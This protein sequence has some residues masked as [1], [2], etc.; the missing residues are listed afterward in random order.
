MVGL[1]TVIT[2]H[3]SKLTGGLALEKQSS[4]HTFDS[5]RCKSTALQ[6]FY[7]MVLTFFPS[8]IK[9]VNPQNETGGLQVLVAEI[10]FSKWQ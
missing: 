9:D 10:T 7:Q 6:S 8:V 2:D 1:Q 4:R 3:D 5:D